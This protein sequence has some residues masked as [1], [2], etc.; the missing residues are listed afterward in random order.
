MR[1]VNKVKDL[2]VNFDPHLKFQDHISGTV[3]S[4]YR[5]LGFVMRYARIFYNP[6]SSPLL[7]NAL[8]IGKLE[9]NALM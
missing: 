4:S 3:D 5:R 1:R 2:G 9:Y 6:M 8:E 7:Y